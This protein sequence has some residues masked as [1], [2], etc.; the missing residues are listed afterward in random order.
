M[1][2]VLVALFSAELVLWF[3]EELVVEVVT[4]LLALFEADALC[5]AWFAVEEL[6]FCAALAAVEFVLSFFVL[7]AF[8]A[9]LTFD[10]ELLVDA[11]LLA[12]LAA[13]VAVFEVLPVPALAVPPLD[14]LRLSAAL[15]DVVDVLPPLE[16]GL[17]N[18]EL[19]TDVDDP[20]EVAVAVFE[21]LLELAVL[22]LEL[23]LFAA[24]L[25]VED[26]DFTL[27]AFC[28]LLAVEASDV[29]A[30]LFALFEAEDIS[31]DALLLLA[32]AF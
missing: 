13:L 11:E 9:E 24:A 3:D 19:P 23:A 25:L 15:P 31:V 6:A 8:E 28:A 7:A 18:D 22:L 14:A 1:I 10:A 32:L 4:R 29:V 26:A 5:A 20:V 12:A 30:A 27:L 2:A 17:L 16:D 21:V